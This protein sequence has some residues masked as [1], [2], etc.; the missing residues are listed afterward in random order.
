MGS[1]RRGGE[2]GGQAVNAFGFLAGRADKT[3]RVP[4]G[5][6]HLVL[7]WLLRKLF[8]RGKAP[9][10]DSGDGIGMGRELD[11]MGSGEC[12]S[13]LGRTGRALDDFVGRGEVIRL[14]YVRH[15]RSVDVRG[16]FIPTPGV[17]LR[18]DSARVRVI[19]VF[20][21]FIVVGGVGQVV[22]LV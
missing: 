3:G 10:K 5:P 9:S 20:R 19:L 18:N 4:H 7:R 6:L 1:S 16:D 8:N 13:E 21:L 14:R 12:G 22:H 15:R 11:G 17:W 2:R